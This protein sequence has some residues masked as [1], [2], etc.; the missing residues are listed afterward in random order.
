MKIKNI[1]KK[2]NNTLV[3][4]K[5][6]IRNNKATFQKLD[7]TQSIILIIKNVE[8]EAKCV[9]VELIFGNMIKVYF[10]G[11]YEKFNCKGKLCSTGGFNT[12]ISVYNDRPW[13]TIN[14]IRISFERI[15]LLANDIKNN[16]VAASYK[17]L[18]ANVK[19]CTGNISTAI[20][21][22]RTPNF[23]IYNLEWCTKSQNVK[24]YH[25][26]NDIFQKMN[27]NGKKVKSARLSACSLH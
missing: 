18:E 3:N 19:D 4:A 13:L 11:H 5:N 20:K 6:L 12:G 21:F 1:L 16:R 26:I 27:Q 10:D 22:N 23:N 17:D 9:T 7:A 14:G 2:R 8:I 15:I 25:M 24:H